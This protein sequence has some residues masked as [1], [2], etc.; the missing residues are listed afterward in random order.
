MAT[1]D[2]GDK[3]FWQQG[4][5]GPRDFGNSRISSQGSKLSSSDDDGSLSDSDPDPSS[6]DDGCSSEDEQERSR[7]SKHSRWSDLDEPAD[8]QRACGGA[9][10]VETV[11]IRRE[12]GAGVGICWNERLKGTLSFCRPVPTREQVRAREVA[13]TAMTLSIEIV[14]AVLLSVESIAADSKSY[15]DQRSSYLL[16][17]ECTRHGQTVALD[18]LNNDF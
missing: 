6:D 13:F 4:I 11:D 5:L 1:R 15:A 10:S 7:T 12:N 16:S 2:F 17:C 14:D 8:G 3:G 18:I 9:V